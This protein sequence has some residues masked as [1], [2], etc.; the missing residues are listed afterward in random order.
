MA[1]REARAFLVRPVDDLDR[2]IGLVALLVQGAHRLERAEHAEDAVEL[3]AGRLRIEVR[4][5]AD[6]RQ[7]VVAARTAREHVAD[8]VDRD[9]A[10]ERLAL[11][12]EPV[13]HA[14]VLVG[15]GQAPDAALRRRAEL[16]PSP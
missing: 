2:R 7:L 5:H 13:A 16:R 11:R 9:R 1:G 4:A 12:L 10:A 14:L 15:Q 8:L 6:R 3:A